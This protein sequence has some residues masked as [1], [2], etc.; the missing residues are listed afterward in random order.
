MNKLGRKGPSARSVDSTIRKL[1]VDERRIL[2]F[3]IVRRSR[4]EYWS[5][6][7][8]SV[9]GLVSKGILVRNTYIEEAIEGWGYDIQPEWF[10]YLMQHKKRIV[11]P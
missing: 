11:S 4:T 7:N 6:L 1:S 2:E 3:H 10:Q 9:Q 8:R 5:P